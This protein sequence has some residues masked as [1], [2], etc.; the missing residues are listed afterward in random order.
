MQRTGT[1]LALAWL[2]GVASL[3]GAIPGATAGDAGSPAVVVRDGGQLAAALGRAGPGT[4]ILLAPGTYRGGIYAGLLRGAPGRAIVIA[5]LDPRRKPI[6]RGGGEGMKLA[7]PAHIELRDLIIENT[8]GTGLS[9]DD[10]GTYDTPAHHVTVRGLEI[11]NVGENGIKMSGVDNLRIEGVTIRGWDGSGP[12]A[13]FAGSCAI[14]LIGCHGGLIGAATMINRDDLGSI[15]IQ[16]KGGCEDIRV[17]DSRFVHAGPRA[18]QVGGSTSEKFFR[19]APRGYEARGIVVRNNVFVGSEAAIV[20]VSAADVSVSFNTIYR[21][22]AWAIRILHEG[23]AS[24]FVPARGGGSVSDNIIAFRSDE[25]A[26]AINVGPATAPETFLFARNW[27]YCLDQPG[28]SRP[29]LPSREVEGT[30]GVD[31]EFVG[32]EKSDLRTVEG[33]PA[34]DRGAYAR[35]TQPPRGAAGGL[36]ASGARA[37]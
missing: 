25:M 6:I 24:G 23:A 9:I 10:G 22:K 21:P 12:T 36:E 29:S 35:P 34:R 27:W 15:G 30:Y 20:F 13:R 31:P 26:E 1:S 2:A 28:R 5:A 11:R 37:R 32:P 14:D 18:L 17:V 33:S 16:L 4:R 8:E 3:A 19:P 7:D